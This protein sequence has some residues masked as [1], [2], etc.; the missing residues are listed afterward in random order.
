M[1][2]RGSPRLGVLLCVN[3]T[4]ILYR[5]LKQITLEGSAGGEYERMNAL[6]SKVPIG[7]EGLLVFPYGNGAER[8]LGNRN[9][10]AF[11]QNIDFNLHR[12]EHLYRASQEGIVFA[13]QYGLEIMRSMGLQVKTVKAGYT[14]MFLSPIFREAFTAVTGARLLL[15]QTDGAEG[16]ARG[17]ALGCGYYRSFEETFRGLKKKG[18]ETADPSAQKSYRA[19]YA[20][21]RTKLEEALK[22]A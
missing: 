16:A 7:S 19:A 20:T 18:E 12:R 6:A 15:Y 14:N 21:W 22:N 10:G 8:T 4:G 5:W 9:L 17:A 13:L 11:F 2:E 1:P 3:G